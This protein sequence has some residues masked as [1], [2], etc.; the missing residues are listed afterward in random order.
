MLV[1]YRRNALQLL[2][3][4]ESYIK[5]SPRNWKELGLPNEFV[6]KQVFPGPG[7][8]VRIRGE[9]TKK[10]LEQAKQADAIILEELDRTVA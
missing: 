4:S 6:M 1:D 3:H 10:R 8:A 2:E 9:V 5:M 7:Y